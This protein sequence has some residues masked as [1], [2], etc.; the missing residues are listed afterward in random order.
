VSPTRGAE[1]LKAPS[2]AALHDRLRAGLASLEA[3]NPEG[4]AALRAA[5]AEW[6]TAQRAWNEQ[7]VQVL[8]L[9]HEVNN[10]LVG[11]RGNAQLLERG[12][13]A[14]QPGVKERLEVVIRESQRIHDAIGRLREARSALAGPDPASRAA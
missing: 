10:A 6:W 1:T 8:S 3:G 14:Q 5:I 12:P 2:F 11:I 7:L 13:A 4:A 9:Y